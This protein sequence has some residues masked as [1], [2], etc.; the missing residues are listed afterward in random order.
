MSQAWS[1]IG[2]ITFYRDS[3][4]MQRC[5][6]LDALP[7]AQ[8]YSQLALIRLRGQRNEASELS[9]LLTVETIDRDQDDI[10]IGEAHVSCGHRR[11]PVLW[12]AMPCCW[13]RH[14][15]R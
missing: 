12:A 2:G 15:P 5:G 7:N 9:A 3:S 8:A 11:R 1:P 4:A 6:A 14:V 10:G 13:H